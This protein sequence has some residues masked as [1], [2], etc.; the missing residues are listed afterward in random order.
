MTRQLKSDS[1]ALAQAFSEIQTHSDLA[2]LLDLRPD[3][4]THY[5]F[6]S[7][8]TYTSFKIR[9]RRGGQRTILEPAP[10]LKAIQEKLL[11]VFSAISS[12]RS[13]VHGFVE[14]RSIATNAAPHVGQ[15]WV[16]NVDLEDFFPSINFGRVRG[17]F[18][19]L[20]YGIQPNLA[21]V[22]ARLCTFQNQLPQGNPSSPILSNMIAAPMDAHI[23]KLARRYKAVYTRFADDLTLSRSHPFPEALGTWNPEFLPERVAQ[24]GTQ[25]QKAIESNGFRINDSKIR[26]QYKDQRQ[27]VTGLTVNRKVNVHRST[28]RRIRAM[29]HAWKVY[30]HDEAER[31]FFARYDNKD[32]PH[33]RP[34]FRQVVKGHIDFLAFIKGSDNPWYRRLVAQYARLHGDY[35]PPAPKLRRPPH[36][37]TWHDALW[38]VETSEKQG[39]A[40]EVDGIG[41]ITCAHV[42]SDD[43]G[44][45]LERID[46]YHPRFPA[47]KFSA[48]VRARDITFDVAV[49]EIDASSGGA[50]RLP[51]SAK[52]AD[53]GTRVIVAG[54]PQFAPGASLWESK[55]TID[56]IRELEGRKR[57]IVNFTIVTGASGSPVLDV[58]RRL[59]GMVKTGVN[60][61]S[62]AAAKAE[63]RTHLPDYG[64]IPLASILAVAPS[65]RGS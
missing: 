20:P 4:L 8:R 21:T 65:T 14:D 47:R 58:N 24:V 27:I 6:G 39:T 51:P 53:R 25:L 15:D 30:G 18:I 54:Y 44:N 29:L 52:L 9:K 7:G 5:S 16:L 10:G 17:M 26:L 46:I 40:F 64:V 1:S 33:K 56:Q 3:Q 32:R 41:L 37:W 57:Y 50:L 13:C 23:L 48:K 63:G 45:A 36:L 55:G 49:L 28:P 35:T 62:E 31:E 2:A 59:L 34:S 22:L 42:I 60:N 11:Q 38:V 43:N 19:A 12:P 61:F